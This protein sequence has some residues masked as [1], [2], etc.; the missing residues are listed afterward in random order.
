M[1]DTSTQTPAAGPVTLDDVRA[2]LGDTDP[3]TTN[4]S[5]LR[6]L[7]GRGGMSTIQKHLEALRAE[8][9]QAEQP[10]PAGAVPVA[11]AEVLGALWTSAYSAAELLVRRRLDS[12]QAD[13][14]ALAVQVQALTADVEALSGAVDDAE[15]SVQ[16]QAQAADQDRAQR[17]SEALQGQAQAQALA[18]ALATA[19]ARIAGLEHAAELEASRH[20]AELA[21]V[22]HDRDTAVQALQSALDRAGERHGELL[23]L[24]QALRPQQPMQ[25]GY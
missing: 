9:A 20:A 3:A 16:A 1:T 19:Q 18:D 13:R 23:A 22:G 15:A 17:A 5:K 14:D 2:A 12:L 10:A 6:A 8:R 24:L 21:Q 25:G 4:A 11:P 7:L